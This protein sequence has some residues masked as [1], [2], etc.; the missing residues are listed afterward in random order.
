MYLGLDLGTSGLRAILVD[1]AGIVQGEA[2]MI[3]KQLQATR[4]ELEGMLIGLED[5]D[6]DRS[7]GQTEG[8]D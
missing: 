6:L 7:P 3:L 5:S 8:P 4:G 2:E 1:E